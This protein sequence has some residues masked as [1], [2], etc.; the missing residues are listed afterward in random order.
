MNESN[1][2]IASIKTGM[3][4]F[5]NS[6]PDVCMRGNKFFGTNIKI[7]SDIY[8]FDESDSNT[9]ITPSER[10]ADVCKYTDDIGQD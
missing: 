4:H 9:I 1:S 5:C 10:E 8:S 3:T 7:Q 6:S 2:P